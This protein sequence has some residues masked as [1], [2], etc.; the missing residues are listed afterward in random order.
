MKVAMYYS[1][2]DIR[3]ENMSKPKIGS[4]EMLVEMRACGICGSDLMEWYLKSRTP[5]VLG[6][7]PTGVV[8]K[9]GDRVKGF[10]VGDRVFVHHHVACLVCHYCI[11]GDYTLC[12]EFG[13][14][15]IQ[16]GGFAEYFGVPSPNLKV[17]TMKIP[18]TLSF[19]EAT[20]IEPIACCIRAL[21]K[22]NIQT[23][24]T[25]AI[26]GA[27]PSG[28]IHLMLSRGFGAGQVI[29]SDLVDYRLVAARGFG[30]DFTVNPRE[31]SLIERVKGV[32]DGRGADLVIVTAPNVKAFGDGIKVCRRGGTVCLFAPVDPKEQTK[33][34]VHRLFFSEITVVPSYSTSHLETRMALRMLSSGRINVEGLITHVFPLSRIMDAYKTAAEGKECLKV[35]V[36]NE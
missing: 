8:V 24:D 20:L 11:H 26:I 34:S 23:G 33:M 35:V 25:V 28:V 1:P 31:E 2:K 3:I 5:L 15:H 16:P 13:R 6:H 21:R 18:D 22:C 7:E 4:D 17:D 10:R 19:E 9:A 36:V 12:E 29:V 30:A 32:T 14:T 27:G